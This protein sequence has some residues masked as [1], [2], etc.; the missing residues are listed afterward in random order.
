MN[1]TNWKYYFALLYIF[2][3]PQIAIAQTE[4]L[5]KSFSEYDAAPAYSQIF[6]ESVQA[7]VEGHPRIDVAIAARDEQRYQEDEARSALY[8]QLEI[9]LSG[10]QRIL[11][12]FEDRFD[13]ITLRSQRDTA[14]NISLTGRQ[15]IYDG[16]GTSSRIASA[17]H[18]FTAAHEEYSLEASDV[19]LLAV[20]AHYYMI[21]QRMRRTIHQENIDR[22]REILNM[23]KV[24]FESG[25]GPERDVAL[26][27]ARLA[28]A[29]TEASRA[30]KDQ[31]T[32]T[33]QY[34]EIYNISPENLK[35]PDIALNI[36][37]T[38]EEALEQG[39]QNNQLLAIA[40]SRSLSSKEDVGAS[41]AERLPHLSMELAATKYDLERGNNDY[42]VTG[43][44]IMN[45]NL[46]NGGATSARISKSM[47]N[48][49]RMRHY[50]DSVSREVNR[51]IKVA[52]QSMESQDRQ[53]ITL[54]EAT[55]ANKRNRD[56]IREQ[57]EV[58]GGSL[59]SLL[60]AEKDYHLVREQYFKEIIEQDL[61]RYRLLN[62]TGTL[63]Q[64][65]NIR[66]QLENE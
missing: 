13:N 2:F 17:K 63:L 58:T 36:P 37:T 21:F 57:F 54:K 24:R 1:Y 25:R 28:L 14:A 3:A 7:A 51:A 31:E 61:S 49:E 47:R 39:F 53:V 66:L 23:V 34:E 56:Q 11:D 40:A 33:S 45:Y 35:R 27:E 41:K 10:R 30:Q 6:K 65:L 18:A 50:Q 52:F 16:G 44:L 48:Y 19:A 5:N 38:I 59:F 15:L 22:H 60:E 62:A 43:R 20:E 4:N 46:Y 42:D 29:E 8:P 32:A 12:N 64:A 9:G 26:M 55:D